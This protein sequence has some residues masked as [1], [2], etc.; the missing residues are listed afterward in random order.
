[1]KGTVVAYLARAGERNLLCSSKV[2]LDERNL[3]YSPR[4]HR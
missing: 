2:R 1:M 4:L 3:W